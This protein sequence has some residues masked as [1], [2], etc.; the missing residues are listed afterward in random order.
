M[1]P[2]KFP[3]MTATLAEDQPEYQPLPVY[4]NT[5]ETISCWKLTFRERIKILFTGRL[6]LRQYNFRRNLQPQLP[7]TE[8]P[9]Q[10]AKS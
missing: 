7:Q 6:W 8:T 5:R 2:V 3:E 9:F 10:K 1:K 4:M